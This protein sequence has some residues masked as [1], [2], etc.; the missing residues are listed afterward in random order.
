MPSG[1]GMANQNSKGYYQVENDAHSLLN[2]LNGT[3]F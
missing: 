3:T 1:Y 2:N